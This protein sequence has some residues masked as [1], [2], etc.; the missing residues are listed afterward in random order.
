MLRHENGELKSEKEI[1]ELVNTTCVWGRS[2]H[3]DKIVIVESFQR[4]GHV[5]AM[6]G[7]GVNDVVR[8]NTKLLK[9]QRVVEQCLFS[10]TVPRDQFGTSG[11]VLERELFHAWE[12]ERVEQCLFSSNV[13]GDIFFVAKIF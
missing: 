10:S 12:T 4:L 2:S 8:E 11:T 13:P 1:D 9:S 6:T 5:V 3:V 7:D